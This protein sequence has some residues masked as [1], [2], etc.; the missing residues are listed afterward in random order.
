MISKHNSLFRGYPY[1]LSI[2][3][4]TMHI[5]SLYHIHAPSPTQKQSII[6]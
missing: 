2:S 6:H 5:S 1:S 3:Y 4:H